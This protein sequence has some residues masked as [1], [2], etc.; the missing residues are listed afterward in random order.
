MS[1]LPLG[2]D[3]QGSGL[4][5]QAP[6]ENLTE[7]RNEYRGLRGCETPARLR[8][9]SQGALCRACRT[10]SLRLFESRW[11]ATQLR[12]A[13]GQSKIVHRLAAKGLLRGIHDLH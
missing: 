11:T 5:S 12:L 3:E 2:P 8:L 6:A 7:R 4:D 10:H 13:Q 9:T 1:S